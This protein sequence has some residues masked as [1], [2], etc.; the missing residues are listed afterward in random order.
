MLILGAAS[1]QRFTILGYYLVSFFFF[2]FQI[3][4]QQPIYEQKI[5]FKYTA[6]IL[7]ISHFCLNEIDNVP[8]ISRSFFQFLA[9]DS[10]NCEW[11]AADSRAL[12]EI[13]ILYF[14]KNGIGGFSNLRFNQNAVETTLTAYYSYVMIFVQAQI[15]L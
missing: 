8:K 6:E 14:R 4:S 15:Q 12:L 9:L 7:F 1:L 5:L 13:T 11:Q 2:T 10:S 3:F